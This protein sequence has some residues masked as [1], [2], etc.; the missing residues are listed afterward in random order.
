MHPDYSGPLPPVDAAQDYRVLRRFSRRHHYHQL[1]GQPSTTNFIRA[2][3]ARYIHSKDAFYFRKIR[4]AL[5]MAKTPYVAVCADDDFIVK[6]TLAE[7]ARIL[8]AESKI[9]CVR[10]RTIRFDGPSVQTALEEEWAR[11]AK[12][13]LFNTPDRGRGWQVIGMMRWAVCMDYAVY[14][15]EALIA[16]YDLM[17]ANEHLQPIFFLGL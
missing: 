4:D 14:R 15:K 17:L 7:A 8:D 12:N 13:V 10:G 3:H 2:P 6:N 11:H 1:L 16:A 5:E 9:S